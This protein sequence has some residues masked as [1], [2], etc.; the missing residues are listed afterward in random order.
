MKKHFFAI[1]FICVLFLEII[2]IGLLPLNIQR[3]SSQKN[4]GYIQVKVL[5]SYSLK[6]VTNATVCVI[7][8]RY[9][10]TTDDSGNTEKI[11][12]PIYRNSTYDN[13]LLRSWGEIT[14][15]IYKTGYASHISFYNEVYAG[16]TRVGLVCYLSQETPDIKITSSCET[17]NQSY[18]QSLIIHYQK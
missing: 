4:Y 14:L 17:P 15:L 13:T 11:Q 3:V 2:M 8:S 9:Y 5:D 12:V 10:S 16:V 1:V 7:E 18:L 6:P